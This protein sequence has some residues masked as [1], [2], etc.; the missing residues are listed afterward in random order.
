MVEADAAYL[1]ALEA[2]FQHLVT[3]GRG[4]SAR[5]RN[6]HALQF[7][8]LSWSLP[9]LPLSHYRP[10]RNPGAFLAMTFDLVGDATQH[11]TERLLESERDIEQERAL[12]GQQIRAQLQL[13]WQVFLAQLRQANL[14]RVAVILEEVISSVTAISARS[15]FPTYL[16]RLPLYLTPSQQQRVNPEAV[17]QAAAVAD[18]FSSSSSF[19]PRM[20][21]RGRN[22]TRSGGTCVSSSGALMTR[23]G[24]ACSSTKHSVI[25]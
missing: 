24:Q 15:T 17:L 23:P 9:Q 1:E 8:D 22:A 16:E 5:G 7:L 13:P 14:P 3:K 10:S 6:L 11:Y 18:I 4:D 19:R 12:I 2:Y 20:T 21:W 25:W